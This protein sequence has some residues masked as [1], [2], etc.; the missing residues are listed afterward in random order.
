[1]NTQPTLGKNGA[2]FYDAMCNEYNDGDVPPDTTLTH[3]HAM[4]FP[5]I[6]RVGGQY[7]DLA[8]AEDVVFRAGRWQ[9]VTEAHDG[10]RF[11]EPPPLLE[12][13]RPDLLAFKTKCLARKAA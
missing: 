12:I 1:M 9:L 13:T 8:K 4:F 3:N 11:Y 7:I 5:G 10:D 2:T 6:V